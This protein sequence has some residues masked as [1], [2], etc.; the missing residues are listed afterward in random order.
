[1]VELGK[2]TS[3]AWKVYPRRRGARVVCGGKTTNKI[4]AGYFQII[5]SS[6]RF[7]LTAPNSV[8]ATAKRAVSLPV[9][10]A[11]R[12]LNA[13]GA[14]SLTNLALAQTLF[15]KEKKA[16]R[17]LARKAVTHNGAAAPTL[18]SRPRR[19][20]RSNHSRHLTPPRQ[21]TSEQYHVLR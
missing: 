3:V 6:R 8:F 1:M 7:F 9:I 12:C 18:P 11:R 16:G 4:S 5:F 19:P 15:S 13:S 20:T 21:H 10:G 14:L 17:Q 2:L